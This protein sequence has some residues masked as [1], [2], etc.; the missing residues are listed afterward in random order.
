MA[1]KIPEMNKERNTCAVIVNDS[2]IHVSV[3][4][5]LLILRPG[6]VEVLLTTVEVLDMANL[7]ARRSPI[8]KQMRLARYWHNWWDELYK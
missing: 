4:W 8:S 3:M 6:T 1:K 2:K 7:E 5:M